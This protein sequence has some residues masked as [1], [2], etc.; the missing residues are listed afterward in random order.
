MALS[1]SVSTIP[2]IPLDSYVENAEAILC[3][4]YVT[5]LSLCHFVFHE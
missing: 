1:S 3:G 5:C 4:H 2:K